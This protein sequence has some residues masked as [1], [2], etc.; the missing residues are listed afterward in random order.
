MIILGW[1]IPLIWKNIFCINYLAGMTI[2]TI[3]FYNA[4]LIRRT[5]TINLTKKLKNLIQILEY[6]LDYA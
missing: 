4:L 1:I 5:V 6:W 3:F 2:W